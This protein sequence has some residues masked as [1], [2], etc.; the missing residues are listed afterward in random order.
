MQ[1]HNQRAVKMASGKDK[2]LARKPKHGNWADRE[3]Y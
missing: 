3:R 1:R 2:K